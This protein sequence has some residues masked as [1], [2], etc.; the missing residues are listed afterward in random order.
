MEVPERIVL[1]APVVTKDDV[2]QYLPLGFESLA[3][4]TSSRH[5]GG[6]R[7]AEVL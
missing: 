2:E 6:P 3:G 7:P 4:G 5:G 1:N